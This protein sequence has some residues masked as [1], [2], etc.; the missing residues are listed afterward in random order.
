MEIVSFID[1]KILDIAYTTYV[2]KIL[3]VIITNI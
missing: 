2:F 3:L 1:N